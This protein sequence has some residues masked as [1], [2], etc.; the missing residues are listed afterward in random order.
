MLLNQLAAHPQ[1]PVP[2]LRH[3]VD[4]ATTGPINFWDAQRLALDLAGNPSL[5]LTDA[6]RLLATSRTSID[7]VA[8]IV[9]SRADLT[10]ADALTLLGNTRRV[11]HL[12]AA[13]RHVNDPDGVVVRHALA[14][15]PRSVQLNTD[16]LANTTLPGDVRDGAAL[17]LAAHP[18]MSGPTRNHIAAY[19]TDRVAQDP[20]AGAAFVASLIAAAATDTMRDLSDVDTTGTQPKVGSPAWLAATCVLD[21]DVVLWADADPKGHRWAKVLDTRPDPTGSLAASAWRFQPRTE[22]V[23]ERVAKSATATQQVRLAALTWLATTGNRSWRTTRARSDLLAVVPVNDALTYLREHPD[24]H[25][26]SILA[27]RTDLTARQMEELDIA[28]LRAIRRDDRT[29]RGGVIIDL[30]DHQWAIHVA[31]H[32]ATEPTAR[33][34]A[35]RAV[36]ASMR[37]PLGEQVAAAL[38]R[39]DSRDPDTAA[40][41]GARLPLALL[42]ESR[43]PGHVGVRHMLAAALSQLLPTVPSQEAAQVLASLAGD[44]KGTLEDLF[45]TAAAIS[46]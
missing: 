25:G 34:R 17:F 38:G 32:P 46:A 26:V 7:N 41:A 23:A 31:T 4:H 20:A 12:R 8:R 43:W 24:Q 13:V 30:S 2:L 11:G 27:K 39:L 1:T 33:A 42:S 37:A 29:G 10:A 19:A 21:V 44:L 5:P 35:V 40:V 18:K 9:Y 22:R 28:R 15:M 14:L 36:A 6:A 3:L 16:V 45:V